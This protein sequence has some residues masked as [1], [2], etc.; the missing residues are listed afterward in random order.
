MRV[1]VISHNAFN[2]YNNMGKTLATLFKEYDKKDVIQL[3]FHSTE[4]NIKICEST[5]Q[6]TDMDIL[7][8]LFTLQSHGRTIGF[9]DIKNGQSIIQTSGL[10]QIGKN[11]TAGK[12]FLRDL[13]WKFG[14]WKSKELINWL[15]NYKPDVIFLAAGYSMFSSNIAM[16]ISIKYNIPLVTYFCDDYYDFSY[17]S[18]IWSMTSKVRLKLFRNNIKKLVGQSQEL[19]F[20]SQSMMEKYKN[21]FGKSGQVILTPYGMYQ[22]EV[23]KSKKPFTMS[24]VGNISGNRWKTLYKIGKELEKINSDGLRIVLNIY[25]ITSDQEIISKLSIGNSLIFKGAADAEMV[26]KIYHETDILLHVESFAQE[27]VSRVRYSIST[28]IADCLASNRAFLAVGPSGIASIDYLKENNAAYIIE[29]ENMIENKLIEYF[30]ENDIDDQIIINAKNL[31]KK[32][33][34]IIVNSNKLKNIFRNLV[35]E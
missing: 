13:M 5:Y 2:I 23:K 22:S 27:D 12:L 9:D 35:K 34:D 28:K 7:K 31:A 19:V 17:S 21:L 11:K 15:N 4:P 25:S 6:I 16:F 10:N 18:Y 33:H 29:D 8:S 1:L 20:I 24:F 14:N 30:I 3:C 32:N 26:K